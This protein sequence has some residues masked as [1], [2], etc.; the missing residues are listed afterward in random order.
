[1]SLSPPTREGAFNRSLLPPEKE[2]LIGLSSHQRQ[3]GFKVS[4]GDKDG[5]FLKVS[6]RGER[7]EN[8]PGAT[9]HVRFR[10]FHS[11]L[12]PEKDGFIVLLLVGVEDL[13]SPISPTGTSEWWKTGLRSP[14]G[15]R[16]TLKC[17]EAT[18]HV[19]FRRFHSFLPPE[20]DGGFK[21]SLLRSPP[22]DK[23]VS[24]KVSHCWEGRDKY[25]PSGRKKTM[26]SPG[27]HCTRTFQAFSFVP[28]TRER[29][30]F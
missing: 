5:V 30:G 13:S 24:F 15:K 20:K 3:T 7:H 28:P 18:A 29:R 16:N 17:L 10:H 21:T 12:S 14:L 19:R 2:R 11:F 8:L 1:M 22:G 4:P 9:A 27:S 26:K 25:S 6:P 23:D